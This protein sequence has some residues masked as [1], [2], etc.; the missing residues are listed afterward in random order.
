MAKPRGVL[1]AGNWKMNH[2]PLE[3]GKF[4][5]DLQERSTN[6]KKAE[7]QKLF[8]QESLRAC[9]IPPFLSLGQAIS[10]VSQLSF[11]IQV[12]AQNAHW[13]KK[14]AFTGEVS[15]P[16][17]K[18]IGISWALVGHSERRQY[19]GETDASVR[20]RS[21]SLLEQGF[22]VILCI[23][24]TKSERESG[25]TEEV[26]ARQISEGL[27]TLSSQAE[28]KLILAYEPVWAIGTGLTATPEQ[29]EQTHQFIREFLSERL[30]ANIA[31]RL[32]ILYGGSVTPE[33]IDS[34]LACPNL[35]GALVGGASLK[36]ESFLALLQAGARVLAGS[37]SI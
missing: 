17:L 6:W 32:P 26:L 18:E 15:G 37:N 34:L 29:A 1:I 13:E 20:K 19:F 11:P 36:A 10:H 21:E 31:N 12:A 8:N 5:S 30:G 25:R 2:G 27:P 33:N 35:D 3:T 4:F 14:G 23:G 9:L 22:H 28:A 24:E 7:E 16:M